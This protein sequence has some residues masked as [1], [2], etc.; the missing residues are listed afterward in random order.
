MVLNNGVLFFVCYSHNLKPMNI[1]LADRHSHTR[2]GL[3]MLLCREPGINI[4]GSAADGAGLLALA[5]IVKPDMIILENPLPGLPANEL[6][7]QLRANNPDVQIILTHTDAIGYSL[8]SA[9][10][11]ARV[12]KSDPPAAFLAVFRAIRKAGKHYSV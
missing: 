4:I 6:I 11:N 2:L 12:K 9:G 1:L 8:H 3:E 10:E 5:G 7:P